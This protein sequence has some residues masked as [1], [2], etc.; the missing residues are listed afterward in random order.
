MAVTYAEKYS[1]LVDELF[2][3]ESIT[4]AIVNN[5]YDWDG[6]Q[7]IKVYGVDVPKLN[8]YTMSGINRYGTPEE[9]GN[10]A[11]SYMLSQDKAFTF[12]I[13]KRSNLDTNGAMEAGAALSKT[14]RQVII[15]EIDKYRL[16]KIV[17]DAGTTSA[18]TALSKTNIYENV[19]KAQETLGENN[20][21]DTDR[22]IFMPYNIYNLLKQDSNFVK[23]SDISQDMLIRGS[24]GLVDGL[25]VIPV[26][27]SLLPA[28]VGF[29]VAHR[30]AT[31]GAQKLAEYRTHENPVGINGWLVEGRVYYDAF[32]LANKA[33]AI[34]VHKIA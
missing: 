17:A 1:N 13:D 10:T 11:K 24:F 19:L 29:V 12:T 23:Q 34:Y 14:I 31:I 22:V 6:V 26:A 32:V 16:S 9:L 30:T 5:S 27:S 7:T 33:K 15:P 18:V 21:P 4:D 28:G 2:T 8:D 20:V 3:K 25:N